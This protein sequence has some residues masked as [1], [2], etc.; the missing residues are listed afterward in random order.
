MLFRE[1]GA[2]HF[3]IT[4]PLLLTFLFVAMLH[5][6]WDGLPRTSG[7]IIPPGI[8]ISFV[9]LGLSIAGIAVLGGLYWQ[10]QRQLA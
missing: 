8:A 10:A 9:T 7:I 1:S 2:K 6:L 4:I 3:R 5:G